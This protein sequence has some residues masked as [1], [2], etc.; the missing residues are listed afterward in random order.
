MANHKSAI[1]RHKQSLKRAAR[2]RAAR[3]R[4]KNAIKNV[5]AAI[6]SKDK[7]QANA[8]LSVAASVLAKAAG[9]GSLHWKKA[10]RK[11]SRLSRAVNG[12]EA[13]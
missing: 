6:Q 11:V 13:A 10:A 12:I 9:K 2:N 7:E 8:A 5:R 1:K 3:T 4:V